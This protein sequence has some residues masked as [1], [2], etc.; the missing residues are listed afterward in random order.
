MTYTLGA[1]DDIYITTKDNIVH[2]AKAVEST[3]Y[4][5]YVNVPDMG[6]FTVK[7]ENIYTIHKIVKKRTKKQGISPRY[8]VLIWRNN[9]NQLHAC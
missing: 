4:G 7:W 3:N 2:E 9:S 6:H 5:L 8:K 1:N